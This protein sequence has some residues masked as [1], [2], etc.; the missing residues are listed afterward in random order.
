MSNKFV[1]NACDFC[2]DSNFGWKRHIKTNKHI[3]NVQYGGKYFCKCGKA[4]SHRPALCLHKKKCTY[5]EPDEVKKSD[6]EIM[7]EMVKD[8]IQHQTATQNE[9]STFMREIFAELVQN[10]QKKQLAIENQN[11]IDNQNNIQQQNNIDNQNNI[12]QQNNIKQ[13]NNF[14]LHVFLNEDCK[15]A[16]NIHD[17]INSMEFNTDH[18]EQVLEKG[19][20]KTI[21]S[22][23]SHE[24]EKLDQTTRPI[25]CTDLKRQTMFINSG[26]EEG[27]PEWTK[28]ENKEIFFSKIERMANRMVST[29]NMWK[30]KYPDY[31]RDDDLNDRYL[32][33]VKN[34]MMVLVDNKE[35]VTRIIGKEVAPK[36]VIDKN[37]ATIQ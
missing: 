24:L 20:P 8:V 14:N 10:M 1:C 30:Q 15:N 13:L 5:K 9:H 19:L 17:F 33:L 27:E 3:R 7:C 26:T 23:L 4:Y 32:K 31:D 18:A 37:Q 28:D 6:M 22:V 16:M 35:K 21:G 25:H 34:M 2:A 36:C 12:Q 29:I 11:N